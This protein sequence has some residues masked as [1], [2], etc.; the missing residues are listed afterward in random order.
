M[1]YSIFDGKDLEQLINLGNNLMLETLINNNKVIRRRLLKEREIINYSELIDDAVLEV[2]HHYFARWKQASNYVERG[3]YISMLD[4]YLSID[5]ILEINEEV[6]VGIDWTINNNSSTLS[7]KLNCHKKLKPAHNKLGLDY[8]LVLL[9]KNSSLIT[10]ENA[11][12]LLF[13]ILKRVDNK[14]SQLDFK[15]GLLIDI[16]ELIK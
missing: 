15:G 2:K 1:V 9:V 12:Q 6:W 3:N 4:H 13:K 10:E 7:K 5:S 11:A 16:K 8:S 14:V